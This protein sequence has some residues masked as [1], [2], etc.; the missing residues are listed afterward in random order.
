[1]PQPLFR[2]ST[3]PAST[4]MASVAL[5][6][7]GQPCPP[8]NHPQACDSFWSQPSAT[9]AAWSQQKQILPGNCIIRLNATMS[10]G[11]GGI[12]LNTSTNTSGV[13]Y[14]TDWIEDDMG[15][16]I[17][18][19]EQQ[20]KIVGLP[21][22]LRFGYLMSTSSAVVNGEVLIQFYG[23]L[24]NAPALGGCTGGVKY[25][26]SVVT[27]ASNNLGESWS[28]RSSINWDGH[29]M[30]AD[31]EG[32]CEPSLVV[33]PDGKTL[34]SVFRVDSNK[35]MWQASSTDGGRTF[36]VASEMNAWAVFPQLRSLPNGALALTAGRPGIGL[37]IADGRGGV[38]VSTS[39]QFHNL[40]VAH[41]NAIGGTNTSLLYPAPELAIVNAS[42]PT[43][44]PVM[45]KA[46]TGLTLMECE[47]ESCQMVVTYDRLSNGNGGPDPPGPHGPVDAAFSMRFVVQPLS[48][49]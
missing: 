45:T 18:G 22:M 5:H 15:V 41:N 37:W 11:L 43:S 30:P 13:A 38:P 10:R 20:A 34:L 7:D 36:S 39:W 8:P 44:N 33:L 47:G 2:P 40:A 49:K 29:V 26:Y 21:P 32:P 27:L 19:N 16:R 1:M 35:N 42:S 12:A 17:V 24:A 48:T 46:Y 6:G 28:Y 25:C 4:L 3:L 31:V 23:Y 9:G 14:F